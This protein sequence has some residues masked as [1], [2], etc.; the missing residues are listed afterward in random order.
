MEENRSRSS[1]YLLSTLG[2]RPRRLTEAGDKD[3][4]ALEPTR[5]SDRL[6]RQSATATARPMPSPSST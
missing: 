2:G 1:L 6:H 5:R 4:T 3:H